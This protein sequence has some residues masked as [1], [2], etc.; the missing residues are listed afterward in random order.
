M[1]IDFTAA[2]EEYGD[3]HAIPPF[4]H[5]VLITCDLESIKND[6]SK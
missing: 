2:D 4:L 3:I 6:V 1:L 5:F